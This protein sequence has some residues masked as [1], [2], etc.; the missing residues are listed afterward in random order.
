MKVIYIAGP[1][2]AS[3]AWALEQNIRTAEYAAYNVAQKGASF[4]CPHT[5]SRNFDG[6]ITDQFWLDA[7]MELMRRC[8]AVLV[9][10]IAPEKSVGTTLEIIE[11]HRTGLPVFK[12]TKAMSHL[13]RWLE[14]GEEVS[15]EGL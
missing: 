13:Q 9:V 5:N 4:I 3:N 11:A 2:R 10:G 8:D 7:T 6:T 1:Y 15:D 12:G 14:T